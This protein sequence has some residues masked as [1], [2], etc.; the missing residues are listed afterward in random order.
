MWRAQTTSNRWRIGFIVFMQ[1]ALVGAV[2]FSI[3][4]SDW[5]SAFVAVV[6]L[7]AVWLPS[8][9]ERS[10]KLRLPLQFEL[11]L[12]IFVYSSIFLGEIQG[13]Y[14]R[15]WWWDI[16][17][18]T[19]AGMALGFIG[20]L[21]LFSLYRSQRLKMSPSLL[22]LF[23]FCFALALGTLWEI[24]EYTMDTLFGFNMQKSGLRDTMWDMIVNAIGA[25]TASLTGW[26][27]MKHGWRSGI[28]NYHLKAF[29]NRNRHQ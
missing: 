1:I 15:F 7:G 3:I 23:S 9:L 28:F 10:L 21:I 24:F 6:A 18:H 29:L 19:S 16:V 17:L 4:E 25:L 2:F 22:A 8:L 12:N 20:F 5:L 14:T 27:Y 13:F 11:L 26:L